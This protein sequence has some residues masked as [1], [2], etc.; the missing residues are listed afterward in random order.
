MM[1]K[2]QAVLNRI[3]S[4]VLLEELVRFGVEDVCIAPGSRSTPLAIEAFD[5][6]NL[7]LH[8]HFDERG[9]AFLAHGLSKASNKSVAII[10]TSGTAAAN[11]LPAIVEANLTGEKLVVITADRPIEHINCGANQAIVQ[12]NIFSSHVREKITLP[13]PSTSVPLSWLLTSIDQLMYQ[14]E[15]EG[16]VIHFNCPFPEPLY[17]SPAKSIYQTYIDT[18]HAWWISESPFSGKSMVNSTAI[19][20]EQSLFS[21]RGVIL[22]GDVTIEEARLAKKLAETIGWPCLCD[23]QSGVSSALAH[24]DIW[25][26]CSAAREF[27]S[28]TDVILQFG[29][30]FISKRLTLWVKQQVEERQAQYHYVSSKPERDNPNHLMQIHHVSEICLWIDSCLSI[31]R[32]PMVP[33]AEELAMYTRK[34]RTLAQGYAIPSQAVT[35]IG[36]ATTLENLPNDTQVVL[37]NS[38]FVRLVDMFGILPSMRVYSNRGASGIDGLI[39]TAAGVLRSTN[40]PTILFTGDTSALYDLN[41]LALLTDVKAPIVV[42][43]INNDGGA[44]FDLL[45]VSKAHKRKLYQM[46][47]GYQ[48]EYAAQQFGLHYQQPTTLADYND[49]VK[50]HL[51]CGEGALVIELITPSDQASFQLKEVIKN[52]NAC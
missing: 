13:S 25:L 41:S 4:Q 11:L 39:A 23:P 30:R 8:T 48:F 12:T 15:K 3:W 6:P 29:S 31:H 28:Q 40:R 19:A 9:L 2:N 22:V 42:A 52:I 5:N 16:G 49:T 17:E 33:W 35:E 46:P 18:I 20:Q 50:Q 37:G 26:Q 34:V 45:P 38:L 10:V 7:T 47:H 51:T 43:V 36:L 24:Y 44:I 27:L 32:Q 14:Q 1:D 21:A